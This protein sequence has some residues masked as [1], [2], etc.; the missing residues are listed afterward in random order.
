MSRRVSIL[1]VIFMLFSITALAQ[2]GKIT[3]KVTDTQTGEALIGA[4]V[5][6]LNTNFGAATDVNGEYTITQVPPGDY[7]LRV[8]FI[9]YQNVTIQNI[10]VVAGLTQNV[11]FSMPSEAIATGEIV[12]I[13]ERPL[14]EKSSTN[15]VRIIDSEDLQA[16]PVR[17]MNDYISLQPGIVEQDDNI[18]IR[19]SRA[20]ETGYILE[21]VDVKNIFSRNGGSVITVTPDALQEVLVQAGGYTAEFGNSNAGIV[22]QN[23]KTG[24]EKY[25][26]SLRVETDNFGNYP[27]DTFLDTYSYGYSD[28][29]LTA[30]GPLLTDKVKF[31]VS[32]ENYFIRD[33]NPVFFT[34]SP[35]TYSDGSLFDTTKLYDN[36]I[37]GGTVGESQTL[38][39]QGGNIQGRFQNRYT[40]N[41]NVLI[42]LRPLTIKL[43]GA[44]TDQSQRF[45][46]QDIITIFAQERLPMIDQNNLLI[47]AKGTYFLTSKS[48]LEGDISFFD[49]RSKTYDPYFEDNILAYDDSLL[50]SQ[51]GWEY[52]SYT[53]P[54]SLYNFNG[55]PFYRSGT[56][57]GFW[58]SSVNGN[59]ATGSYYNKQQWN[60]WSGS[61]AYT[62]QLKDHEIRAGGSYQKWTLRRYRL[63]LMGGILS[64]IRLSPDLA[65]NTETLHDLIVSNSGS[66]QQNYGYDVFGNESDAAPYEPKEPVFASGYIQDKIEISDLIINAGLRYDYL[67]MD[68]WRIDDLSNPV[69]NRSD[70]TIPDSILKKTKVFEYV[71]PRIGFSFPV[72]D[73]TVFHLQYGKFVQSPGLDIAFKGITLAAHIIQGGTAFNDVVAYNLEPIRTTQYEIGFTQQFTDFASFDITA[74]YKDI[75][76]Q[77]AYNLIET[78][79]GSL[80]QDY[81]VYINQDFATTKGLEFSVKVR[82]V[83]RIRAEINY[84]FSDTRGT[85]SGTAS[86]FGAQQ[87][88][89]SLPTVIIPLDYDQTHRGSIMFDYRFGQN[90]GGPILEQLGLSLLFTFNSGH[91]YT[92]MKRSGLGQNAPWTGGVLSTGITGDARANTPLEPINSSS[93]PW[94]YNINLRIDKT[95]AVFNTEFNFYVY[96]Q[97]LLNTKNIDNIYL[98][99]GNAYDDGF[100]QTVDAQSIMNNSQ[101]GSRYADLYRALNLE[102]R[103]HTLNGT[104]LD[105][106]STPRQIRV[107][108]LISY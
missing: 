25:N 57:V 35:A 37:F 29:V 9:G 30:S 23:F 6:I 59:T 61:L 91:P 76:G 105:L 45:N 50:A 106:F 83:E 15:A 20:D 99:T 81:P 43:S 78:A 67:D 93:T 12:I 41:G 36:G 46:Y 3:G 88:G 98:A 21:G 33:Y 68:S 51:Y 11:D 101:Y 108:L 77:V 96:V 48:F 95:V 60:Y 62:H 13:A 70:W 75:K 100:L 52:N 5:L 87:Q 94:N 73:R 72:T 42:D 84:T 103:Q 66:V 71:S 38:S 58:A 31:F 80:S 34:G 47:S 107:G 44:F 8:S 7:D 16:L 82:R 79:A 63:G 32:G 49:N 64:A 10:R 26:F 90:D 102:N 89:T 27:G 85:G 24:K 2:T 69:F 74:F 39:W 1:A 19:G 86:G 92:Q 104:G 53:S 40:I 17:T 14:I 28:Y 54:P 65:R 56:P 18:Y 4:N 55:F 22:Q 97:N